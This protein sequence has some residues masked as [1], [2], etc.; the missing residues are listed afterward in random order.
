MGLIYELFVRPVGLQT[1]GSD[2]ALHGNCGRTVMIEFPIFT[3][4]SYGANLSVIYLY[5]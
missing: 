2:P 3:N 1:A 4:R 5:Y